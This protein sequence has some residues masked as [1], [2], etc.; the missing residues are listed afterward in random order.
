MSEEGL[1][2]NQIATLLLVAEKSLGFPKLKSIHDAAVADLEALA[3]PSAI[4][5]S[6]EEEVE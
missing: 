3:N 1:D 4:E 2:F 5:L 6:D